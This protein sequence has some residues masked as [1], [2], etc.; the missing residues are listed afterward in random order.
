MTVIIPVS[1]YVFHPYKLWTRI[2]IYILRQIF[3]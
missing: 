3:I 1:G 2:V